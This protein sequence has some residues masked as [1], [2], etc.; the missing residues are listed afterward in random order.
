VS[1]SVKLIAPFV[2]VA[3]LAVLAFGYG[4]ADFKRMD[5]GLEALA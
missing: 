5:R 2:A 1:I 4:F 3:M